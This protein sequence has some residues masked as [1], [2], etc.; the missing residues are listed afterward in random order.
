MA[1]DIRVTVENVSELLDQGYGQIELYSSGSLAGSYTLVTTEPL[2]DATFYYTLTHSGGSLNTWYK[3]R[4]TATGGGVPISGYSNPFRPEGTTRL[5]IRQKALADY[6]AGAVLNASATGQSNSTAKFDSYKV[7]TSFYRGNRGRGSWLYPTGGINAGVAT[8]VTASNPSGGEFTVSPEFSTSLVAGVEVE[9]HWLT[10][11]EEWNEAIN[12][13][14]ARYSYLESVPILG[15]G[16]PEQA[17]DY[18]PWLKSID[19][20]YGLWD[21]G[22]LSDAGLPQGPQQA[23]GRGTRWWTKREDA[24]TIILVTSP[25]IQ[26]TETVYLE[27]TRPHE[28]M[29]T[30]EDVGLNN[31]DIEL[32]AALAYDEVLAGLLQ[33]TSGAA[34]PDKAVWE[35]ARAR[36]AQGRLRQLWRNRRPKP[37]WQRAMPSERALQS[38]IITAR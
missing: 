12:R 19:Q 21:Y 23:W 9:W 22:N 32:I 35:I 24:G 27:C 13:G 3:Y 26:T 25:S 34:A 16:E 6:R 5:K 11:P 15:N 14:L 17:L 31:L 33:P 10:D 7:A 8:R 18:L 36:H 29:Y 37:R 30:D 38:S 20:T 4:F 28:P 1:I 2:V